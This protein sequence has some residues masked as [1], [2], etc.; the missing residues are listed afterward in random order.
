MQFVRSFSLANMAVS[1]FWFYV[2]RFGSPSGDQYVGNSFHYLRHYYNHVDYI[3]AIL[4]TGF[5]WAVLYALAWRASASRRADWL[6]S[7]ATVLCLVCFVSA[8]RIM[9][10]VALS[11]SNIVSLA[12]DMWPL[13]LVIAAAA[14]VAV[15]RWHGYA[16]QGLTVLVTILAPLGLVLLWNGVHGT[17]LIHE[18]G[19]ELLSYDATLA[20]A[21]KGPADRNRSIVI[22]FD[23]WDY[24]AT[25]ERRADDLELP[26]IDRLR[27][28][29]FF[30]SDAHS[31]ATDT[32][33]SIPALM[34]GRRYPIVVRSPNLDAAFVDL[35]GNHFGY[36]GDR[37]TILHDARAAGSNTA[38]AGTAFL[39]Y[40][41]LFREVL[42][43][44]VGGAY[45]PD[46][47]KKNVLSQIDDVISVIFRSLPVVQTLLPRP[48]SLNGPEH[49][50]IYPI[51]M[52]KLKRLVVNREVGLIYSHLYLPHEP[53]YFD[54][55]SGKIVEPYHNVDGYFSALAL[56]DR[57]IGDLRRALE[58]GGL[59]DD[60][61]II[62]TTD[63]H[64]PVV[65]DRPEDVELERRVPF[66]VKLAGERQ[67]I[68]YGKRLETIHL[69][70]LLQGI[71][72]G[73]INSHQSV[74]DF[75]SARFI[76]GYN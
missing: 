10:P 39:P 41:K 19:S 62:I 40:C 18:R 64:R 3:S 72:A 52:P 69:R 27:K 12:R 13:A 1:P 11:L 68:E 38:V 53:Y 71:M 56:V 73:K 55:H 29:A 21:L 4:L 49:H 54:R 33:N 48:H 65:R 24:W 20:P 34:M 31:G 15:V 37:A 8:L 63:H 60:T 5:L 7:G 6:H 58:A 17:S 2:F 16:R 74:S 59:W 22:I 76:N 28:E 70:E 14:C 50:K 66:F 51:L 61:N 45:F 35:K 25:F 32:L 9:F 44:C 36:W 23:A 26:E 47:T 30:A 57:T 42:T 46:Q 75:F 67:G 43:K